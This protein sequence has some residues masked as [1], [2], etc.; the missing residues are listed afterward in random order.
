LL[1]HYYRANKEELKVYLPG[2][3]IFHKN[4]SWKN[5]LR[6]ILMSSKLIAIAFLIFA[7]ARPR[8]HE[9]SQRTYGDEGID[10]VL[11][12]DISGSMKAEDFKPNRMEASKEVAMEFVKSRPTDRIGIVV[13]SGESFTQCPL[14]L[15]HS[16]AKN[17]LSDI[18]IGMIED[19]STAIGMGL[20]T[21]VNRLKDS[22][23]KS[24][25]VILLTDGVNNSGF[26]DP[27][28]AAEIAKQFN[29]RVYTIGVGTY[30]KA[31]FPFEGPFGTQY[32]D[33]DVKIDED[34][35]LQVADISGGKYF[36]ANTK[37]KLKTIYDEIDQ[38]E[39]TELESIAYQRYEELF[40]K[41]LFI[42]FLLLAVE[43]T[44]RLTLFK[45]R[46]T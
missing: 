16:I 21:S 7:L 42:G 14:T 17:L 45:S 38:M 44:L 28:T 9:L 29:I 11:A 39:K 1:W 15:D 36:R 22:K 3:E 13:Y 25:V 12:M 20:A 32:Q 30:G 33:I 35:L 18:N 8:T 34:V 2:A 23:A 19:Q 4:K 37:N 31:P 5:Y 26:I 10:I 24:K 41:Y 43:Y 46:L 27:V 40:Y 6:T